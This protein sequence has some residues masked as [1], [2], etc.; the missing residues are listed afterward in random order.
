MRHP[1]PSPRDRLTRRG[2]FLL[3]TTFV[4]VIA[5]A[6]AVPLL[7][8][9]LSSLL[10]GDEGGLPQEAYVSVVGLAGLVVIFC[11]YTAL[12][13]REL[14]A[15]RRRLEQEEREKADV[16]TRL[17]E[18]SELFQ[19]S[20][21]LNLQLQLDDILE[22]TVRR[23]VAALKAQQ[24]SIMIYEPESGLLETRASYGLE[25]EFARRAHRRLG[26]GIAGWVAQRGEAVQLDS[27]ANLGEFHAQRKVNRH[28]TSALSLPL[29]V[30]ARC[31]GV[32][33][34][35]RI[36]HPENFQ[37][38]HREMLQ[39]FADHAGAVI[40]RAGVL[41][42]LGDRARELE[43][44]NV[45]L[46][47]LNRLK[48]VFL[49][50]ASH[51]LKTPLTSV[52]GYAEILDDNGER[53]TQD[54]RGEF[55]RRLRGE[56]NRLLGLIEDI[57][58]LTRIESGKLTLRRVSMSVNE[59]AHAAVETTRS[60]AGKYDVELTEQL[61]ADLPPILLDEVK[62]RQVLVNLL[63]NAVKFSPSP[64]RVELTTSRDDAFVRIEVTDRGAGIAPEDA[65]H[66]FEL[67]GQGKHGQSAGGLGIGLH[68]VKRLTEL[69]GGHVGVNSRLGVG[70]TFWVRL[71]LGAVDAD[72]QGEG[73]EEAAAEAA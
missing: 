44:M 72:A 6:V 25:S 43:E 2:W 18:L 40:E 30:G 56:A 7:Y 42:R 20:T 8:L 67:F 51:E 57:L 17:S 1:N 62:M 34:V 31:V 29:K 5:L 47:E 55:L 26:E 49:S 58:D 9:P 60:L 3:G 53:M 73:A 61:E 68:L 37:L 19:L 15:M 66:I 54:Q 12:K 27:D 35:N 59:I 50:T 45:R 65:T 71:P 33:N 36:N 22:I 13:Q 46:N 52:I 16:R 64:G 11:L 39:L 70:S 38:H 41:D 23:V 14:D 69:H 32:L 24:A 63:G 28:I 10:Q 4:V 48:D 21:T